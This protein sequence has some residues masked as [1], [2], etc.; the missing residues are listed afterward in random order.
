MFVAPCYHD[1]D[2]ADAFQ[3]MQTTFPVNPLTASVCLRVAGT[4]QGVA[5]SPV[6]NVTMISGDSL[7]P[8]IHIQPTGLLVCN[9]GIYQLN[10][11]ES[12]PNP[13]GTPRVI[14]DFDT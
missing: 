13:D 9:A 11:S 14:K 2:P 10:F 6:A 1:R 12:E 4:I 8:K 5:L 3:A 7:P